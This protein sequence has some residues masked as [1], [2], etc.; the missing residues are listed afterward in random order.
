MGAVMKTSSAAF[1]TG[2]VFGKLVSLASEERYTRTW[3]Q[4]LKAF[5]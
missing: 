3:S 5:S 4:E 1:S 2:T